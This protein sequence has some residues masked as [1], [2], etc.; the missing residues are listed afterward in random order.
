LPCRRSCP[1]PPTGR[2]ATGGCRAFE[3]GVSK[4]VATA[5]QLVATAD[6]ATGGKCAS[7]LGPGHR[8]LVASLQLAAAAFRSLG[9]LSV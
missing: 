6:G 1:P 5:V 8:E 2:L 7:W 3:R 9:E 4:V